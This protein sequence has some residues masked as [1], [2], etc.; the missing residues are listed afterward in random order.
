MLKFTVFFG[1][2]LSIIVFPGSEKIDS[3]KRILNGLSG[4]ERAKAHLLLASEFQVASPES[5]LFHAQKAVDIYEKEN[6]NYGLGRAYYELGLAYYNQQDYG[7]SLPYYLKAE[8]YS[9]R[10]KDSINIGFI[11]S[12]RGDIME[13]EGNAEGAARLHWESYGILFRNNELRGAAIELASVGLIYWRRG[14]NLPAL[15]LFKQAYDIRKNLGLKQ[16]M[17]MAL[18]NMGVVYWR[19]GDYEKAFQCYSESYDLRKEVKDIRGMVVTENNIGLIFLKLQNFPEAKKHFVESLKDAISADYKFG[20][21][22]SNYNLADYYIKLK[23]YDSALVHADIALRLYHSF[24]EYNSVANALNYIGAIYEGKNDFSKAQKFYYAAIDTAKIVNDNFSLATSYLNLARLATSKRE[25]NQALQFANTA[26][27]FTEAGKIRDLGAE[28]N[29]IKAKVYEAKGDYTAA[30]KAQMK[31]IDLVENKTIE[32]LNFAIA[33]WQIKY[34]MESIE[35]ENN[36][37]KIEKQMAETNLKTATTIQYL[38]GLIVLL[39][40]ASLVGIFIMYRRLKTTSTLVEEKQKQLEQLNG[41]LEKRN[42]ALDLANNT[43]DKLF[44]II[45]HDLTSP[46]QSILGNAELL[47]AELDTMDKDEIRLFA[48][49]INKSSK[50][51]LE[52]TKNLLTWSRLQLN[53]IQVAPEQLN[54]EDIVTSICDYVGEQ[55]KLKG[56][57]TNC[58]VEKNLLFTSDRQIISTALLNL[59]TNAVK[60]TGKGGAVTLNAFFESGDKSVVF[61]IIDSGVGIDKA[62]LQNLLDGSH[63]ESTMG[64]SN[65]KGTGLGI[66]ITQELVAKVGGALNIT[67]SPGEGSTFSIKLPQ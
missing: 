33:N 25:Y 55:A 48:E 31:Y 3:V 9:R 40:L 26:E 39:V 50:S 58:N 62:T 49:N 38:L 56:I 45:S 32:Q 23:H 46:F 63:T 4:I 51:L 52:L 61:Q 66:M 8:Q 15:E 21:A 27:K 54:A 28:I 65:E 36:Q 57:R 20:Q 11:I 6:D 7:S 47:I 60:F 18:N 43:K 24:K 42:H 13:K 1:I 29:L 17:A 35:K 37:L 34:E 30:Y 16:G 2:V 59:T 64:T 67:S 5:S 14:E 44:S 12:G 53:R 22:Y 19:M 10:A 41:E